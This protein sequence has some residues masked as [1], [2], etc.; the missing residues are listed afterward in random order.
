MALNPH[1][2]EI[3]SVEQKPYDGHV[4]V[5]VLLAAEIKSGKTHFCLENAD[6]V[7]DVEAKA[8]A[9]LHKFPDKSWDDVFVPEVWDDVMEWALKQ[10]VDDSVRVVAFDTIRGLERL[11]EQDACE[12]LGRNG[13][14]LSSLY[15]KDAGA[16]R[17]SEVNDRLEALIYILRAKCRK[18]LIFTAHLKEKYRDEE[19][20]G[21]F[22]PEAPKA[23]P[24]AVNYIL[25]RVGSPAWPSGMAPT[26]PNPQVSYYKVL[27]NGDLA[28][29]EQ[30]PYVILGSG[31]NWESLR[32]QLRTPMGGDYW[33]ELA[34]KGSMP[35]GG[36]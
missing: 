33:V 35:S 25:Q 1:R 26:D 17:Y 7:C 6:R 36:D 9:I 10:A 34:R 16:A 28:E 19:P 14:P 29:W 11:A 13:I 12:K 31:H 27:A 20:T 22:V 3:Q 18:D 32:E 2:T 4:P 8:E 24:R 15:S 30:V 23:I 5:A 21:I